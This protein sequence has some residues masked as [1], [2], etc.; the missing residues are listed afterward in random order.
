MTTTTMKLSEVDLAADRLKAI[1]TMAERRREIDLAIDRIEQGGV[2]TVSAGSDDDY[3][4]E[5]PTVEIAS[6]GEAARQVLLGLRA[7][8]ADVETDLEALGVE[9][10]EPALVPDDEAEDGPESKERAA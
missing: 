3:E 5:V 7:A 1:S 8:L 4:W 2:F 6:D 10:D 9:I